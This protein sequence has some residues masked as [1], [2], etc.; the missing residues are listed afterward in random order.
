MCLEKNTLTEK[1]I[2]VYSNMLLITVESFIFMGMSFLSIP[3]Q[4]N[5]RK[6]GML[7]K[8]L[9]SIKGRSSNQTLLVHQDM[10]KKVT[11]WIKIR[12]ITQVQCKIGVW[13]LSSALPLINIYVCKFNFNP[14][15]TFQDMAR[16]GIHY[17]KNNC[18]GEITL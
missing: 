8:C 3:K 9:L 5:R 2:H 10:T 17:E 1:L 15:Y 16:T 6:R 11:F 7:P 14:F 4:G 18:Y 12:E 13:F